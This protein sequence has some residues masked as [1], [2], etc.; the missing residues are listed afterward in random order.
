MIKFL[1]DLL[2]KGK[3]TGSAVERY[4]S[5]VVLRG[6]QGTPTFAELQRDYTRQLHD[7]YRGL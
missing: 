4:Y 2:G 7:Q 1:A 3:G 5:K 6:G